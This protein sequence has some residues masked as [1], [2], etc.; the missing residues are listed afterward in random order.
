[1]TLKKSNFINKKKIN[2]C[3]HLFSFLLCGIES[4]TFLSL[5]GSSGIWPQGLKNLRMLSNMTELD[6]VSSNVDDE[7][8]G[9]ISS[10]L[11]QLRSLNLK[12]CECI[13]TQGVK[14]LCKLQNSE[15]LQ[16]GNES[17]S[18]ETI[19][20]LTKL[21]NLTELRVEDMLLTNEH[22]KKFSS[23]LTRLKIF[24]AACISTS[25]CGRMWSTQRGILN[26]LAKI[27]FL[28]YAEPPWFRFFSG[29]DSIFLF[30][31]KIYPEED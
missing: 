9:Q 14:H 27:Q 28:A 22:L 2:S 29:R 17:L 26:L 30:R 13:T 1:L 23:S 24:D 15:S 16:V 5:Q 12:G 20:D 7:N 19:D 3:H 11:L 31:Q 25:L 8:L 18:S 6:L 4:L 21:Q 10:H